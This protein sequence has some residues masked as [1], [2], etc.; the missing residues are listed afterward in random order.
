[1]TLKFVAGNYYEG[2]LKI[3]ASDDWQEMVIRAD[4]LFNR[5]NK[6]PMKNWDDVGKIHFKPKEGADITKVIFS[7]FKWVAE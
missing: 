1:M 2:E 7:E 4:Q 5:F 6:Q 3:T